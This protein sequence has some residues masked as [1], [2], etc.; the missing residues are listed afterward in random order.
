M[1][2][3]VRQ[4]LFIAMLLV[5]VSPISLL[6]TMIITVPMLETLLLDW[7]DFFIKEDSHDKQIRD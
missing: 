1:T 3:R 4:I 2:F 7:N 5:I 6:W